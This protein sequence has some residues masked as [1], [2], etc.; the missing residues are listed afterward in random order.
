MF[1]SYKI[2][3][4]LDLTRVFPNRIFLFKGEGENERKKQN[5]AIFKN[6]LQIDLNFQFFFKFLKSENHNIKNP[7]QLFLSYPLQ[8]IKKCYLYPIKT[9]FLSYHLFI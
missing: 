6:N 3:V 5:Y 8:N 9:F 4:D 7:T 1:F 2:S